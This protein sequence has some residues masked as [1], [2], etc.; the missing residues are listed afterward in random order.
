MT[1]AR[2]ALG[3]EVSILECIAGIIMPPGADPVDDCGWKVGMT[4]LISMGEAIGGVGPETFRSDHDSRAAECA[5]GD[6]DSTLG[7][8]ITLVLT[9]GL[10][11]ADC[12]AIP[13]PVDDSILTCTVLGPAGLGP[14][15]G[16]DNGAM[17][18]TGGAKYGL[19]RNPPE[20]A[21][22]PVGGILSLLGPLGGGLENGAGDTFLSR[23]TSGVT[24]GTA[25]GT[26]A[27]GG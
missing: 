11:G 1:S 19:F 4:G 9:V 13:L 15:A 26:T 22:G 18:A 25:T 2:D 14:G 27:G 3:R 20:S 10:Y 21:R 12:S 8:V 5:A 16:V 6:A 24:A 23:S 17:A 7:C